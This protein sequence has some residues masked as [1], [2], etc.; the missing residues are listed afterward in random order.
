MSHSDKDLKHMQDMH[1][2]KAASSIEDGDTPLA[3]AP[4][5]HL[6]L[7]EALKIWR[8]GIG[9]SVIL[10]FAVIMESY[11]TI[12]LNSLYAAPAFQRQF[13]VRQHNGKYL[14]PAAW[15]S[16]LGSGTTAALIIGIFLGAPLIDRFGSRKCMIGGL[17]WNFAFG[18]LIFFSKNLHH[19]LA[20]NV[21]C[22]LP[23]GL[24][25]VTAVAYAVEVV[26]TQLRNYM[27]SYVFER[28]IL[29]PSTIN[30]CWVMGHLVGAGV[31][32]ASVQ[33]NTE[34]TYKL[35]FLL[36]LIPPVPLA[37]ALYFAPESP[38]YLARKGRLEEA[39]AAMDRLHAEHASVS[40]HE[41]VEQ[42]AETNRLENEMKT[43]GTWAACFRGINLRRTEIAIVSW[44]SPALVGFVFQFFTTFFFT[45][46]GFAAD[47]AF[48]LGLGNYAIAFVGTVFSWFV[49]ARL[50]RR[51]II[52]YGYCFMLPLTTLVATLDFAK[53]TTA[54]WAQA[55]F[56]MA[57]FFAYGSSQGPV[58]YV[59]ASE[60]SAIK[61]RA[62]TLA[63]ARVVYYV[64][65]IA[66]TT[67]AP[68]MFQTW[69]LKGKAA[70]PAA[71][72]TLLLLI[73]SY[74]RLPEMKGRSFEELDI[75]FALRVP[76]R[77]FSSY[78]ITEAD[79]A[80]VSARVEERT[81]RL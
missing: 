39:T 61:L 23:W 80:E 60:S 45:R 30:L 33:Y 50:G 26:P 51:T 32:K 10:S 40:S 20:G 64:A 62:K 58:P 29:E 7:L 4:G 18:F 79:K 6:S 46:A 43:G 27:S 13:G 70:F 21:L 73:W 11:D 72:M 22:G 19:L 53:S 16:A 12:L 75:L 78:V 34:W 25:A 71:G 35:P 76:A 1:M 15:Q 68:Y 28:L 66:S 67:L 41:L 17:I 38:Y 57:Y 47:R 8:F 69:D 48:A 44:T 36:I 31:L 59:I 5:S 63:L 52:L 14:I 54:H 77:G 2:E 9:W 24:F 49:Q 3:S 42:I 37:V 74:F 81:A 56:V 55:S 65:S